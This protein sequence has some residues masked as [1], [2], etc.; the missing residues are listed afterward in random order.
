[1]S[2]VGMDVLYGVRVQ[3][4]YIIAWYTG[5]SRLT[6]I[7]QDK[8]VYP[9]PLECQP[10]SMKAGPERMIYRLSVCRVCCGYDSGGH[11]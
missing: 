6:M 10:G 11:Y 2:D 7:D 8:P 4:V 1:M 3:F 5:V 9:G